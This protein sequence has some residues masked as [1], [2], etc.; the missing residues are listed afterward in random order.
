MKRG[1]FFII[2]LGL[3]ALT[4]AE[5]HARP[6]KGFHTGPYLC[7]EGGVTQNSFDTNQRTGEKIGFAMEPTVGFL[8][9]WNVYDWLS[10]EMVG[11]YS[12]GAKNDRREHL[13]DANMS[14]TAFLVTDALTNFPTL[15]ILPFGKV[16]MAVRIDALPGDTQSS[17]GVVTRVGFGPTVGAGVMFLFQKYVY[18]G[19]EAQGDFINIDDIRQD[20]TSGGVTTPSALIYK[21]GW[22][23]QFT[24][25]GIVGVHF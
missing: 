10:A 23:P 18:M 20:L 19:F 21:G 8:F 3:V 7:I 6:H 17:D 9:G 14:V 25:L 12:T 1:I 4:A 24:A 5:A 22:L 15:R 13:V 2:I 16:G 11:R